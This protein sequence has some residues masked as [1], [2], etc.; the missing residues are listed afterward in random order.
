MQIS[1][2]HYRKIIFLQYFCNQTC[3]HDKGSVYTY[4]LKVKVQDLDIVKLCYIPETT[5]SLILI[6]DYSQFQLTCVFSIKI[7]VNIFSTT[8]YFIIITNQLKYRMIS[9]HRGFCQRTA[10][11]LYLFQD[12][13][14]FI[15][16]SHH[17][18][19]TI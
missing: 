1:S 19:H 13:M 16:N 18:G 3:K 14:Q 6:W 9:C 4:V 17:L 11:M 5:Y 15:S 10:S 7:V 12:V 8:R 2:R